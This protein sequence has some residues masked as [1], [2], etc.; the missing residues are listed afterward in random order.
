MYR[1]LIITALFAAAC[2]APQSSPVSD[3]AATTAS[4]AASEASADV[5][6][7]DRVFEIRTYTTLP[8]RLD[9]LQARFRDHTMQIF[10][11]HGMTNVGYWVPQDSARKDNTLIYII[12]HASRAQA[13]KNWEAFDKDPEW[14]K[15]AAESEKD[16]KIIDKIESV[17]ATATDYSPIK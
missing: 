11:K 3:S 17:Y 8:G 5:A 15:V 14:Q 4:T 10:E 2:S 13:D 16:G 6:A 9:A 12:S 1:R 7:G